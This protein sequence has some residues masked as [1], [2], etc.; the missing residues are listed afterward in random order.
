MGHLVARMTSFIF[1][2]LMD[3][4]KLF[5]ADS[6]YSLMRISSAYARVSKAACLMDKPSLFSRSDRMV[7]KK[8][9]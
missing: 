7:C 9:A 8:E 4:S 1:F 3:M 5:N 6:S 2:G